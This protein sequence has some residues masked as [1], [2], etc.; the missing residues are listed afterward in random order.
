MSAAPSIAAPRFHDARA[1]ETARL[2]TEAAQAD[3]AERARL[4]DEV[5]E[6]NLPVARSVARRFRDRGEPLADLEQVAALG[7]VKAARRFDIDAGYDFLSYAVPTITGEVKRHFRDSAW[8]IRPPRRVQEAQGKISRATETLTV[9]LRRAPTTAE[10]ASQLDMNEEL[11]VEALCSQGCFTPDSLD[12]TPGDS[13]DD[14][15]HFHGAFDDA[16]ELSELR[17]SLGPVLE[18]L[19]ARERRILYLRIERGWSQSQIAADIGVSQMQV[20]RLLSRIVRDFREA[21]A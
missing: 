5:I 4:L 1:A 21:V 15:H 13:G 12:S 6:I 2:F 7:L 16:Y 20:S 11:V 18:R 10:L 19:P 17:V 8:A 9:Q 3:E 14:W